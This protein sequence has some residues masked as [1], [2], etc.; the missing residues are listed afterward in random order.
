MLVVRGKSLPT[1]GTLPKQTLGRRPSP[2]PLALPL[3]RRH[4][5]RRRR[6]AH[7]SRGHPRR[8]D[9]QLHHRRRRA[10]AR[11]RDR[12]RRPDLPGAAHARRRRGVRAQRLATTWGIPFPIAPILAA[13]AATVVGVVVGLPALRIRGLLVGVGHPHPGGGP[14]GV[15]FRNND[16]DGGCGGRRSRAPKLFGI[17]LGIGSGATTRARRSGCSAWPCS[18]AWPSPWRS[19]GRAALGSAMLAVRANERSAAASGIRVVRVKLPGFAIGA[20]IAGLGGT[21]MAYQ[22][23]TVTFQRLQRPRAAS[24]SSRRP[25]WPGSPRCPAAS[26]PGSSPRA[27]CC[28]RSSTARSTSASGSASS[29]ASGSSSP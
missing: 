3:G 22:Q 17:D 24:T 4:A 27:A 1:R 7:C 28:S 26:S 11:G 20:F 23:S 16:F 21:L 15:W 12:L 10:V 13:L 8:A 14:R 6:H 29:A 2:S 25:T 9:Q 18:S 5:G 19:C